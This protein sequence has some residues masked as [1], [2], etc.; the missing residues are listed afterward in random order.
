MQNLTRYGM[1]EIQ[2]AWLGAYSDP[3]EKISKN[4]KDRGSTQTIRK[5]ENR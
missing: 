4:A 5:A 3:A 2:L 1:H